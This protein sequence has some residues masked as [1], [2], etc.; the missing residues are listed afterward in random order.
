VQNSLNAGKYAAKL[1]L[2]WDEK[3]SFV[4]TEELQ[5]K[6]VYDS[7]DFLS[8]CQYYCIKKLTGVNFSRYCFSS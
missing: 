2:E 8:K 1:A 5:I 3:I 4:L 6:R 7:P